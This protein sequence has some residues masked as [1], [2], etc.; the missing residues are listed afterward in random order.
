MK[1]L[2]RILAVVLVVMLVAATVSMAQ[3][4]KKDSTPAYLFTILLG[5]GTGHFYLQDKAAVQ[6]LLL[7]AGSLA[8]TAAGYVVVMSS[9]YSADPYLTEEWPAEWSIG[10]GLMLA[11]S[12][13]YSAVRIWEIVDV[14]KTVN[15]MRAAGKVAM[16]PVLEIGPGSTQVG[17]SLSY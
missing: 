12:L 15:E 10:L 11:G 13:V 5:F 17:V 2:V 16:R 4:I 1:R 7:D 8:V 3:E 6:F 9:L 14:I